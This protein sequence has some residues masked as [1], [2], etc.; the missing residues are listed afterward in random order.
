MVNIKGLDKAEVLAALY[1]GTRPMG[2]G[3][4]KARDGEMTREQAAE[5][6]GGGDDHVRS[7]GSWAG[8]PL[9]FDYLFGRPLKVDIS[10]DEFDPFLYD[11]DAG[12]GAAER[13]IAGIR[14]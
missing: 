5:A 2:M 11:R 7:F 1:N 9:R 3:V 14:K 6:I 13:A 4:F 10:G 12:Q 8:K